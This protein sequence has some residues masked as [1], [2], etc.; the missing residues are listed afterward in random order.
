M[1]TRNPNRNKRKKKDTLS[2]D[3]WRIYNIKDKKLIS[4]TL[5]DVKKIKTLESYKEINDLE[6]KNN[7][8]EE[9]EIENNKDEREECFKATTFWD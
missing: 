5:N 2:R 3:R 6:E 4:L 8:D 7:L 1:V 9:I